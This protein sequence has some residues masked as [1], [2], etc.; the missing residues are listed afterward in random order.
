VF[1]LAVDEVTGGYW[2]AEL[3]GLEKC[4]GSIA[5]SRA[6]KDGAGVEALLITLDDIEQALT[7]VKV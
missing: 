3:A 5:L 1:D 4:A 6:R 2:G 7:E